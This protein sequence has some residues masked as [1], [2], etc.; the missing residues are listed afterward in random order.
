MVTWKKVRSSG[1]QHA[2]GVR[3][4]LVLDGSSVRTVYTTPDARCEVSGPL[5]VPAVPELLV[6]NLVLYGWQGP[7]SPPPFSGMRSE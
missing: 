7:A 2:V 1:R 5:V 6:D 4:G 3:R